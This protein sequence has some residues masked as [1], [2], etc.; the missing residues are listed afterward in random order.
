METAVRRR[1]VKWLESACEVGNKWKLKWSLLAEERK[2][3]GL[4]CLNNVQH[5]FQNTVP[6]I[7]VLCYWIGDLNVALR[8]WNR[9][10]SMVRAVIVRLR[11]VIDLFWYISSLQCT[12]NWD[13][14]LWTSG[15]WICK[16]TII[17]PVEISV[18]NFES[19]QSYRWFMFIHCAQPKVG[20][21]V[22]T[23]MSG[24]KLNWWMNMVQ[25]LCKGNRRSRD[26]TP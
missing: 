25:K 3:I 15:I 22:L 4:R 9:N 5:K 18:G 13:E 11:R 6:L 14:S 26:L 7:D 17:N 1:I 2:R 19:P 23:R 10:V 16:Y 20:Y 21:L 24:V 8:V 12:E